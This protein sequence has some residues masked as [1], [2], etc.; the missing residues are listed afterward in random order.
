[1]LYFK[2]PLRFNRLGQ[3][4]WLG[5]I[6][7]DLGTGILSRRPIIYSGPFGAGL[8][9]TLYEP[10][11]GLLA[12]LPASL[13][14]NLAW[15]MFLAISLFGYL[16]GEPFPM[17]LLTG[18]A[19]ATVSIGQALKVGFTADVDGLPPL[20]A[21]LLI[22]YLNYMGPLVRGIAR[23]KYRTKRLAGVDQVPW[24]SPRQKPTID[25]LGRRLTVWYWDETG[26]EKEELLSRVAW[27]LRLR[28]YFVVEDNGWNPWD[29]R[30]YRGVWTRAEVRALC[31]NHGGLKRQVD[32]EVRLRTSGW[33]KF[34]LAL[35]PLTIGLT[36][37]VQDWRTALLAGIATFASAVFIAAEQV[38]LGRELFRVVEVVAAQIPLL[39]PPRFGREA[40][41][42]H[43]RG[44]EPAST[45]A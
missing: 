3:S 1:M 22:A 16:Q 15:L 25:W 26:M 35:F 13:E 39:P 2:H 34:V 29:L 23:H 28:K 9:Q 20:R 31:E 27:F 14:W 40:K 37:M 41:S 4:R 33:A 30:V 8:F 10:P 36:A 45:A 12:Y 11:A 24:P 18:L 42:T 5:R 44:S 38:E 7:S 6:Y 19:L 21:R 17:L 32:V 43:V